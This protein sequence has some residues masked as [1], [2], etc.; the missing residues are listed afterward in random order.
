MRIGRFALVATFT[1]TLLATPLCHAQR[2]G[3]RAAAVRPAADAHSA[4]SEG[5]TA[6]E[7]GELEILTRGPLHEAFAA[8]PVEQATAR[9]LVREEPPQ[10]RGEQVPLVKPAANAQW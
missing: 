2:P 3:R 1:F 6:I 10:Q 9:P 7:A 8:L 4:D 5:R